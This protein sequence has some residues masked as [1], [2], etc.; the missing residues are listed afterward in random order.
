MCLGEC[1]VAKREFGAGWHLGLRGG[2][3][4][5][6]EE[7]E[8]V[9]NMEDVADTMME[10]QTGVTKGESNHILFDANSCSGIEYE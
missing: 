2:D 5:I 3:N 8:D 6:I 10:G 4:S 1:R 7:G 9:G